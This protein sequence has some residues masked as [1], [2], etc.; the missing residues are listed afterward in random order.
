METGNYKGFRYLIDQD[1]EKS[2]YGVVPG[3]HFTT[4]IELT[5]DQQFAN[6]DCT[7]VQY[8]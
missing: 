4:D 3:R 1:M 6:T 5:S 2:D 8:F 7:R